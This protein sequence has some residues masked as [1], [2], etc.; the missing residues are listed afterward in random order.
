MRLTCEEYRILV[1]LARVSGIDCWFYLKQNNKGEWY[2]FDLEERKRMSLR[3]GVKILVEGLIDLNFNTL[4]RDE[5]CMLS[6][7][8]GN[9]I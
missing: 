7:L 5:F 8:L 6:R 1:K 9:L 3:R 2:V 4:T